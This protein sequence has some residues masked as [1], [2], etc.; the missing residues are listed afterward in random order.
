MAEWK[1]L[2]E[3]VKLS[4]EKGYKIEKG[5]LYDDIYNNVIL[6]L[7]KENDKLKVENKDLHIDM[8]TVTVAHSELLLK[9]SLTYQ[10]DAALKK[11]NDELIL[12]T[13]ALKDK[14]DDVSL[15]LCQ[16]KETKPFT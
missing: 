3:V 2:D 15:E 7:I 4:R 12:E 5:M 10:K 11:E 13:K 8:C 1:S 14:Y 6:E 16:L 9:P